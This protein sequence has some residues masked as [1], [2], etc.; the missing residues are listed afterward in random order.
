[1]IKRIHLV[2]ITAF[3][4]ISGFFF[5]CQNKHAATKKQIVNT[6]EE[7]DDEITDNIKAVLQYAQDNNG[8]IND[9]IKLYLPGILNAFYQK[10]DYHNIW[11]KKE[12]W[13]P[14]A[15]SMYNFVRDAK[16]YGLYPS[17]YHYRELSGIMG[18]LRE[19]S[20]SMRDAIA[21]TKAEL[22]LSDAFMKTAHDLKQGR[23]VPDSNSITKRKSYIDSFFVPKLEDLAK[24]TS[25]TGLFD[26]MQP[27]DVKYLALRETLKDFV[28]NMDT[29]H[30]QF[31]IYPTMD[32]LKMIENLQKRLAESGDNLDTGNITDLSTLPD[33]LVLRKELIKYQSA[34]KLH[35]DGKLTQKLVDQLNNTDN[36]KF[37]RIAI[38]LDRYKL[39]PDS[40]PPTYV[41]VNIP[42]FYLELMDH[43]S[44]LIWSRVVVGKPTTPTPTLTSSISN[45]VTYP[46][47]TIPTSIIRKEILPALKKDPGYLAKKG[48]NLVDSK[49]DVV[50]PYSVDWQKYKRGI[51]WKIMQGSGDDNALGILKFNFNNPYSVYLHD[52][53]QR[54]LFANS[55]RALSHGCVRVQRWEDLAFY[56]A[57]NDTLNFG[58]DHKPAYNEDSIKVWLA[59]KDRKTIFIKNRLPLFIEYFTCINR[60]GKLVVF[61]DLYH[62]DEALALKY[63]ASKK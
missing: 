26:S 1:M 15:D 20:L 44:I 33:S 32:S 41:W 3:L 51:P 2:L 27:K 6:P 29:N 42:G 50:D 23:L 47:W 13:L 46:Q 5:S 36:Y 30:Y 60:D 4:F 21:W 58:N 31:V 38:T 43:D 57:K 54:Y 45:M 16:Y 28:D 34:H 18:K 53:N 7:M 25:L 56:I 19:D 11:S 24:G 14:I 55:D 9:S 35:K 37:K 63:F 49:G 17:D 61:D 22:L 59:A 39:L 52:T 8:K 48:Y 62:L 10:N 12:Q 40:M